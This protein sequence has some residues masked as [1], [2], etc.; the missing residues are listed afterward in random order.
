MGLGFTQIPSGVRIGVNTPAGIAIGDTKIWPTSLPPLMHNYSIVAG[1]R[2]SIVGYW[3]LNIGTIEDA[4]YTLRN[5]NVAR[6]RQ[7]MHLNNV[8]RF[9]IQSSGLT[10]SD[11][12][13]FPTLI[14]VVVS[15]RTST[16]GRPAAAS[17]YGQGIGRD[18][19]LLSGVRPF[20]GAGENLAITITY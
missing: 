18:Y 20:R 8:L 13:Q 11:G 10:A 2:S 19:S 3:D 12:D 7:T 17:S 6:I 5:G 4:N 16:W 9:L 1:A 14:S 15:N